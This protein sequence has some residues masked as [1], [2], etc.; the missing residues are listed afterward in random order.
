MHNRKNIGM[1]LIEVMIVIA[2]IAIIAGVAYPSYLNNVRKTK[3]ADAKITLNQAA[4]LQ[5][6]WYF[7][8]N[9]YS[10]DLTNVG[11]IQLA[12][13]TF[14]SKDG[15]YAITINNNPCGDTSCYRMIATAKGPQQDDTDCL[16]FSIDS[17]GSTN[18]FSDL[19][20][21]SSTRET[22]W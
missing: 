6:K 17:N 10:T 14:E 15:N 21:S 11:I 8:A 5:E 4:A 7:Q 1:T 20:M 16:V 12:D 19:A 13:S 9:Q 2:I 3:R 22:C 18:S